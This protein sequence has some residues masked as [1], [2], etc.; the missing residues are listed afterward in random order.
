VRQKRYLALTPKCF[1]YLQKELHTK[2]TPKMERIMLWQK[3]INI[4]R[5]R[6]VF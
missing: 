5:K 3:A 4:F 6:K 1:E 2:G